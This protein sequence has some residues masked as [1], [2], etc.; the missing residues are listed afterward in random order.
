VRKRGEKAANTQT[1]PPTHNRDPSQRDAPCSVLTTPT[2]TGD[3]DDDDGRCNKSRKKKE[4][5]NHQKK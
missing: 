2:T 4:T 3:D 1:H 5:A